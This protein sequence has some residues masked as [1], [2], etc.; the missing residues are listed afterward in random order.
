M[1][2]VQLQQDGLTGPHELADKSGLDKVCEVALE[3]KALKRQ[4]NKVASLTGVEY[5]GPNPFIDRHM[6]VSCI[7]DIFFDAN[8]QSVVSELFGNDLF[9]WRTNFF[10]K[11]KLDRDGRGTGENIWHH[12]RHFE[13]GNA[14]INLFDTS[15]HYSVTVALT[16]IGMDAGRLE[17]VKGSH[18]PI[19]GFDRD[20]PRHIKEVPDVVQDRVTPLPLKRGEFVVFH[21][22]LLHRSLAFG[23]GGGR[24]SVAA[25][26][27][28]AGTKFPEYG[29]AN[30]AGG[31][32]ALAEP[33][34]YYRET[35][36]LPFN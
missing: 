33:N 25:R 6:D 18:S 15:N 1:S 31:A 32:Q 10:V 9:I 24:I 11:N 28:R 5:V 35:G 3:L 8:L 23:G 16:D 36:V 7:R 12:D 19:M 27:G 17:Y 2:A 14:P 22:S 29:A 34:V 4:Q 30:P 13:S 20:I 26:L 21:A